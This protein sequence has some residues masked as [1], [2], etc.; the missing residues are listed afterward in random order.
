MTQLRMVSADVA[1]LA[2]YIDLLEEV[3]GWLASRGIRQ[4]RPGSF[5]LSRDYYAESIRHGE[6]HLA[7]VGQE[8]V[9]TLRLLLREPVVWPE[10]V[11]DDAVYVYNLAVRR[12]WD[13][14]RFGA[15]MLEWAADRAASIGRRYVRL[16]CMADNRF[17]AEYYVRAGFDEGGQI[18]AAFPEP[19]GTLRLRRYQKRVPGNFADGSAPFA[20]RSVPFAEGSGGCAEGSAPSAGGSAPFAEGSAS[21]RRDTAARAA[22][23]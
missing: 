20:E 19:V 5:R 2:R 3:A 17:L 11:E 14:N 13:G 6:V 9:G 23:R 7:F 4:W 21:L 10:I 8:L 22:T 16:D 18:D 15:R 1:D 12:S